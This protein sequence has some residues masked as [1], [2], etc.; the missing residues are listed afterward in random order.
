MLDRVE[1]GVYRLRRF[2]ESPRADLVIAQLRS[3]AGAAISHESALELYDLSDV[4]PSEV[5]VTVARTASRRRRGVRLHTSP[6]G[7]E[8]VTTR[9]GVTVTTVERTIADVARSGLSDELVLRA[10]EQAVARGLTTPSRIGRFAELRGGRAK[11]L[12]ERALGR[13][14]HTIWAD[15]DLSDVIASSTSSSASADHAT[16]I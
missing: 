4:L 6:L 3:G 14:Q 10:I 8:D 13:A 1:R 15:D 7:S 11:K 5:H 9:D 12:A 2:P 16:L